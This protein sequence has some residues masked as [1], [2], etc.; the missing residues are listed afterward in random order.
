MVHDKFLYDRAAGKW[1]VD[2]YLADVRSRYGGIDS[3][4]VWYPYPNIGVDDRNQYDLLE[5]LPGG[6]A[7]VKGMVSAFHA[8]GVRVLLPY[9]PCK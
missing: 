1:T 4:L 5:S 6:I 8:A 2:K 9:N 3:I 7:G